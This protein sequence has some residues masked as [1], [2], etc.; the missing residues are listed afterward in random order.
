MRGGPSTKR[1]RKKNGY[2]GDRTSLPV[3]MCLAS[4]TFAKLPLPMVLSSRYLPMCGSS[5]V[6][7]DE[8]RA[9]ADALPVPAPPPPP[10]L[11][12]PSDPC[13]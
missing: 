9:E 3:G 10:P 11:L 7:R 4:F 12:L 2:D 5:E 13:K 6:R 1:G 8:L